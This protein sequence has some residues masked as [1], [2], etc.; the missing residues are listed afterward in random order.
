MRWIYENASALLPT[1]VE[2]DKFLL[3]FEIR[4]PDRGCVK[5][6]TLSF[7]AQS[8]RGDHLSFTA[9][10]EAPRQGCSLHRHR[11][12][13]KRWPMYSIPPLPPRPLVGRRAHNPSLG[14]TQGVVASCERLYIGLRHFV[15]RPMPMERASFGYRHTVKAGKFVLSVRL[16]RLARQDRHSAGACTATGMITSLQ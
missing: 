3:V 1:C 9:E 13:A 6:D 11:S 10:K 5:I 2:S 7:F 16:A 14:D 12:S 15:P 8:P 4:Y